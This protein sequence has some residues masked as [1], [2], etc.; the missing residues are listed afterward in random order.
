MLVGAGILF[1]V[2]VTAHALGG[3]TADGMTPLPFLAIAIAGLGF[4]HA[5]TMAMAML[6]TLMFD[7]IVTSSSSATSD[8]KG[9]DVVH[10]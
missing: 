5:Q 1:G 2:L 8:Q 10:K 7:G 4:V 3:F 6:V 9:P